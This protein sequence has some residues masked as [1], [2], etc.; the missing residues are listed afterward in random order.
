MVTNWHKKYYRGISCLMK[1]NK[2]NPSISRGKK[3]E[4]IV[5]KELF[6]PASSLPVA[7][8]VNEAGGRAYEF[9]P[10]HALAQYAATGVFNNTFYV[11][12]EDQLKKVNELLKGVTPEFVAKTAVYA[13]EK[14]FMK[15]MPAY[16]LAY[17]A[18]NDVDTLNKVFK[19]VVNDGRMLRGFVQIIRSNAV[20]RK[21]LGNAPKRLV[22][23]WLLDRDLTA[24]LFD[25]VG[26]DPSMADVIR[27]SHPRPEGEYRNAMFGY[28]LGKKPVDAVQDERNEVNIFM[29]PES[30]QHFERF[31]S[32]KQKDR[33]V[34]KVPFQLLTALPLTEDDWK[35]I[36]GNA[37]WTM[38]RMNLNTF[39]R[40]G[41][42]KDEKMVDLVAGRLASR[43][44]V[45]RS[46]VFPYQLLNTYLTVQKQA[47]MPRKIT[48]A[49]QDAMEHAT[50]NVP[51]INGR[52]L[53]FP[54]VSGSMQSAVTGHRVGAT[55]S[56]R[57]IDV[58]ALV[59]ASI[60]RKNPTAEV[61]PFDTRVHAANL[62]P[63][64]SV[65]TNAE[66]L[67]K[68]GGGGTNCALVLEHC[69]QKGIKGDLVLYVSDNES[70]IDTNRTTW[71]FRPDRAT[72]SMEAWK[73]FKRNN[74][75]AKM[76]CIDMQPNTSTQVP[77]DKSILNIGGF[78]D[79]VFQTIAAFANG[80]SGHW[81]DEIE[82]IQI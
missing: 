74:P 19:L 37:S 76:A 10:K 75:N 40:H 18:A 68:F 45:A 31:K 36:A 26:N 7:N 60:L 63:R 51:E 55:T 44:E 14:G 1:V 21:S 12:A 23:D 54:D 6:K 65:M 61:I 71:R 82:K 5:N 47:D 9:G 49:L 30:V 20:G 17:L 8:S 67:S 70:W 73:V 25:N 34:P 64:D 3:K 16:L 43:E 28:I 56:A 35:G 33:G 4:Q 46:R 62:N 77:D 48:L 59:A 22:Q 58:A 29:L 27:L 81:V 69:N 80:D 39:L 32:G 50:M 66:R 53:V 42:F 11:T 72:S 2:K 41:V 79:N 57:C 52:V 38:T 13:R 24:L 78:S 15:D